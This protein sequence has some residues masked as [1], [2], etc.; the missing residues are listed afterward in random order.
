LF[1]HGGGGVLSKKK[2]LKKITRKNK[3]KQL[4]LFFLLLL[5]RISNPVGMWF[6]DS[7]ESLLFR[8]TKR[9]LRCESKSKTNTQSTKGN[10]LVFWSVSLD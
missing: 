4:F 1:R 5:K 2:I 8:S 7:F 6:E 10:A 3:E 9:E